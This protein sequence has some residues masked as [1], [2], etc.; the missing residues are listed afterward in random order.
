MLVFVLSSRRPR[1]HALPQNLSTRLFCVWFCTKHLCFC[2]GGQG[3]A[4]WSSPHSTGHGLKPPAVFCC[5]WPNIW[6]TGTMDGRPAIYFGQI[7][8]LAGRPLFI[9]FCRYF[10]A[11]CDSWH[12]LCSPPYTCME[13]FLSWMA[14]FGSLT[15][16]NSYNREVLLP[17]LG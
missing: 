11:S 9:C 15:R 4:C 7:A 10:C 17:P 8:F 2:F 14:C 13:G 5:H 12:P 16:G 3:M 1:L 6:P